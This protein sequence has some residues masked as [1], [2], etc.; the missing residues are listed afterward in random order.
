MKVRILLLILVVT[1]GFTFSQ[2]Y[3]LVTIQD[4]QTVPDTQLINNDWSPLIGDTVRVRGI[5]MVKPLVDD[6][7]DRRME[8]YYK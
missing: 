1:A 5:V 8:V 2:Q 7:N 6:K 3:P 4:I